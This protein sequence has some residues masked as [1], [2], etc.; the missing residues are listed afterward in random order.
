MT[1]VPHDLDAEYHLLGAMMMSHRAIKDAAPIVAS[2]DFYLPQ[3]G[4]LFDLLVKE[5][6]QGQP[7]D[8]FVAA[9]GLDKE[10]LDKVGGLEGLTA[11]MT[12]TPA[13]SSAPR[14]AKI[15]ASCATRR[16]VISAAGKV[17]DLA[18][19]CP[20][21]SEVLDQAGAAFS[22]IGGP[23]SGPPPDLWVVDD[24]CNQKIVA[25]APWV[26]PG[27][28][29]QDW[30]V[31]VVGAEGQGKSWI[32]RQV[33]LCAAQGIHPFALSPIPPV[34][35]L[36]VDLENPADSIMDHCI[37][38]NHRARARTKATYEPGRAWLWPRQRGLD[39][40]SRS[41]RGSFEAVLAHC[42][43]DLVA[44]GPLYKA[45]E[46]Q[47][48]ETDEQ[49]AAGLQ[50][51]L[52]DLRARYHF[53]LL[54]EH[55]APQDQAGKRELRPFGSSLWLRWPEMGLKLLP[56]DETAHVMKI[57]RWRGDRVVNS[58]PDRLERGGPHSDFPWIG[59]WQNGMPKEGAA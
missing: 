58:W 51:I 57:G 31:M 44:L 4:A 33:G 27:M 38:V 45:S 3:H 2:S 39:L 53:A 9:R 23:L 6:E 54:M 52:D 43:P 8:A 59:Y 50:R 21:A 15:V 26:I 7:V 48:R 12:A 34:R 22:D 17:M 36:L 47:P 41:D 25:R 18:S 20:D 14:Y 11:M 55:H 40:R 1:L 19:R 30:R 16:R 42:Q 32:T 28:F 49:D 24:F 10:S 29:R 13:I 46:R 5:W 56:T 35:T 37:L